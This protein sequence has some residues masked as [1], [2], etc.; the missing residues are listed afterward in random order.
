MQFDPRGGR[1][2]HWC[3]QLAALRCSAKAQMHVSF[4]ANSAEGRTHQRGKERIDEVDNAFSAA[5]VFG[6]NE[7]RAAAVLFP[8]SCLVTCEELRVRQPEAIDALLH[9][10]DQET[11]RLAL[12]PAQSR[13]DR[14]LGAVDVLELVHKNKP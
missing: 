9:I 3:R 2:A 12:L 5:K 14:F 8:P 10:A 13:D 7:A 6:Q 1:L 4:I 11:V